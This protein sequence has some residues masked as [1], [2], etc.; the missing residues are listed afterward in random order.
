MSPCKVTSLGVK[1]ENPAR[2]VLVL[3][4]V[5]APSFGIPGGGR[6]SRRIDCAVVIAF[7]AIAYCIANVVTTLTTPGI[8]FFGWRANVAGLF[9]GVVTILGF[10]F[11]MQ[12]PTVRSMRLRRVLRGPL[13]LAL[14]WAVVSAAVGLRHGSTG[15]SGMSDIRGWHSNGLFVL[16]MAAV[17]FSLWLAIRA[18]I[19]ALAARWLRDSRRRHQS[20]E[21]PY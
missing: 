18:Q 17:Y 8:G 20:E 19:R 14:I 2:G 15:S 12:V 10:V 7:F 21:G 3:R 4:A 1:L 5:N 16:A 11:G 13:L 6:Y 9:V